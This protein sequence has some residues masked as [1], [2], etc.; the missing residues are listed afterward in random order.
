M[1]V[2]LGDLMS[3]LSNFFISHRQRGKLPKNGQIFQDS[4]VFACKTIPN[5]T[6]FV[7]R[8]LASPSTIE[9]ILKSL[10]MGLLSLMA[11]FP[12]PSRSKKVK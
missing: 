9:T 6:H 4:L 12:A 2:V 1:V 3:K 7:D 5:D 8:F 11:Y 10:A